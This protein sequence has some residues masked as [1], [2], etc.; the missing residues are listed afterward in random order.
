LRKYKSATNDET[1]LDY[2]ALNR[3]YKTSNPTKTAKWW[4]AKREALSKWH[5]WSAAECN[6]WLDSKGIAP[7]EV[8]A[9]EGTGPAVSI[10]SANAITAGVP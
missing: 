3:C 10:L 5:D 1:L 2:D 7:N 6:A 4:S 8:R 9:F